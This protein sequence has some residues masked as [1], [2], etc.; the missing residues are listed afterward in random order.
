MRGPSFSGQHLDRILSLAAGAAAITA[1]AVSLYQASLARKQLRAAA[2]P[3]VA[4]Q[5][6][7]STD[8]P[9]LRLVMNQ[10]VGPAKVRSFSVFVDERP[11][12]TWN[13]TAR[14]LTGSPADGAVYS[15]IGLGTVLPPGSTL[16]VLTL[17]NGPLATAF[18][19][20]AQTR[21][22]TVICYCSVYDECWRADSRTEEPE[23]VDACA[24]DAKG[25]FNE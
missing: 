21:L 2:W 9:Y 19:R 16:A 10:G 18:W 7:Y 5:N 8:R 15:S 22:H 24:R 3:Y 23:P 4:Q 1:V 20:A 17:P 14:S 13:E 11:M 25:T 6:A 12:R